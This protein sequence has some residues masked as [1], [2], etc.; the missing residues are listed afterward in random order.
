MRSCRQVLHTSCIAVTLFSATAL[1]GG[2]AA[3]GEADETYAREVFAGADVAADVW[4]LYSG[5]TLA[6]QG[7]IHGDGLRLRASGGYGQYRYTAVRWV[8]VSSGNSLEKV[9]QRFD[10]TSAFLEA[11]VG[12]QK[13]WGELTTKAFAGI[14]AIDHSLHAAGT[15]HVATDNLNPAVGQEYGFKGS[16][17]LWLNL[18]SDAWTS[19][20][21][22]YTTA[23]QSY[24]GRWR[25]GYRILPTVSV[26]MEAG[27]NGNHLDYIEE[28][29]PGNV[30]RRHVSPQARAGLFARYEWH[31]GEIS[32]S[33]GLA[34]GAYEFGG[35]DGFDHVYGT[36][37]W[38]TRF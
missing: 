16:L 8:P 34:N 9:H 2:P 3:A 1:A 21:L 20:D 17:E 19:L 12:Y 37:N 5:V 28:T 24:A 14:A 13:R 27:V 11:L 31:S 35:V 7:D 33:G 10:G 26:G 22:S 18:G 4:L 25:L 29:S 38:L 6:P 32:L 23:H 30:R 15:V 36:L